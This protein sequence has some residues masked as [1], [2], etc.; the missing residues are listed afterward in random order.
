VV[1]RSV[2]HTSE[3]C[4]NGWSDRDTVWVKDLVGPKEPCIRWGPQDHIPHGNG[5]FWGGKWHPIV[6]Y[7]DSAVV[8][9]K[10]AQPIEMAFGIG[11]RWAEGIMCWMRDQSP[12]KK[13]QFLGT[14][15][16]TVKY[17]DFLLLAVQIRLN[18][19]ICRL[20]CGLGWAEGSTSS[21]GFTRWRQ[22]ALM[23][24]RHLANTTEPSVCGGDA[25]L[26]Q[27]TLTTCS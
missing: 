18:R 16:P 17:R 3:P 6:K 7:R 9:A 8:C 12:H 27:I 22:R 20:G 13:G 19:L 11:L 24:G 4:K 25:A 15:A 26:C 5:Q 1:C 23:G 2:C 10:T 14:G 21:I